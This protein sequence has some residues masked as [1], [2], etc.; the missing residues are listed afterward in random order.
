MFKWRYFFLSMN[1]LNGRLAA[2]VAAVVFFAVIPF[3]NPAVTSLPPVKEAVALPEEKAAPA[4]AQA[5]VP[6]VTGNYTPQTLP[7]TRRSR[8]EEMQKIRLESQRL[9][10]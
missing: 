5:A 10:K 4:S 6:P 1:V 2:A 3:L 9:G 8:A 7:T